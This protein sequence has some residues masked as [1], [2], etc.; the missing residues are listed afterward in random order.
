MSEETSNV[1][2]LPDVV[3]LFPL[4][5]VVLFPHVDL[6]LHIFEP[7]YRDM[8]R[9]A[10]AGD[11]LIGMVLLRGDWRKDYNGSPAI[12]RV[13]CV[14]RIEQFELLPDGRSNL[15]LHGLRS[16]DVVEELPG[17]SYRRARVR[18]RD[19]RPAAAGGA[20]AG[21][22]SERR[23]RAV[24]TRLLERGD[25]PVPGDLWERL[26]AEIEKLVNVLGFSLDL[27]EVEKLSLLECAG[28]ELRLE[29]LIEIIEFRLAERG[30]GAAGARGH[31]PWH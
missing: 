13:G 17:R 19:E 18:W 7:R 24:V 22:G 27:G 28:T 10:M 2:E 30:M 21:T 14:G 5:N 15:V 26:P 20:A 12:F 8:V 4:P 16:F 25:R 11:R 1:E 31:E 23:L 9:D 3:A 29:R 6:P